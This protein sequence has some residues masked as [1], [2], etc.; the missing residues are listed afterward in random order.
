MLPVGNL[1]EQL[2][3]YVQHVKANYELCRGNEEATKQHLIAPLF[4]TLGYDMADPAQWNP[5]DKAK[6]GKDR[7]KQPVDWAFFVN[8]SLAFL[9]EAKAV[10]KRI[11]RYDEQLGDYYAKGQPGLKLGILTTG[12]Q[13]RFFTDLVA[14]NVM[15][16]EPFLEWDVLNGAIPYD[17]LKILQR[18]K[19]KAEL[20]K[21][22][23]KGKR[24][25][26]VLVKELTRVLEPSDDFVKLAIQNKEILFE[27]RNL[28][29]KVIQNWKPILAGAI[30]EW[31]QQQRLTAVLEDQPPPVGSSR[32]DVKRKRQDGGQEEPGTVSAKNATGTTK[33]PKN[34]KKPSLLDA[35]ARVLCEA[36]RPMTTAE[37][38]EV[39]ISKG[40]WKPGKGLT[41]EK[42]LNPSLWREIRAKG[43]ES[44]FAKAEE[45]GKFTCQ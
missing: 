19:F 38:V 39:A 14:E 8:N 2:E 26:S 29:T 13:W 36:R 15:D 10:G 6:F 44:R 4:T 22:F 41:P 3:K 31:A 25:Q 32:T 40:Y 21:A 12:V 28:T 16:R 9:V 24:V 37:I 30:R 23:A 42:S 35:A 5:E 18:A 43:K 33:T 27:T 11:D 20:I 45:R 17:L 34:K 1:K 7:S